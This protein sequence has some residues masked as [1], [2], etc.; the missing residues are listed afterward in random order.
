M[1]SQNQDCQAGFAWKVVVDACFRDASCFRNVLVADAAISAFH[2]EGSCRSQ[3]LF[4]DC[5]L[6][7]G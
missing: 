4:D 6:H 5:T 2:Y 1:V 7:T 3:D